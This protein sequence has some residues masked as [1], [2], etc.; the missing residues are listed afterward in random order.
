[1]TEKEKKENTKNQ[2]NEINEKTDKDEKNSKKKEKLKDKIRKLEEKKQKLEERNKQLKEEKDNLFNKLN[3]VMADFE[4]YKKRMKKEKSEVIKSANKDLI[5]DILPVL[6]NLELAVENKDQQDKKKAYEKVV[7]G[8]QMVIKQFMKVL[9]N[10]GVETI[11]AV[12]GAFDPNF[13]EALMMV[14]DEG[15]HEEEELVVEEFQKGYM[16]KDKVIRPAKVKVSKKKDKNQ[17]EDDSNE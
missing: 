6:D 9:K 14:E 10:Y 11:D 17:K 7:E 5:L 3:R 15:D 13:H 12:G 8:V 1:M 4:N 2:E 16:L